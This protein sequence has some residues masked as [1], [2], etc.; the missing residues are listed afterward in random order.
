MG[1]S[2]DRQEEIDKYLNKNALKKYLK[3]YSANYIATT[4]FA[5]DFTTCATVVINRAKKFNIPTHTVSTASKLKFTKN[6]KKTNK[7]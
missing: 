2:K 6:Q 1:I 7:S 4:L 3:I 5:P